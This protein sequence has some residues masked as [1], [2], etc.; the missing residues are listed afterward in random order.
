MFGKGRFGGAAEVVQ[1]AAVPHLL[2]TGLGARVARR[3][4]RGATVCRCRVSECDCGRT[5]SQ[6]PHQC[7]H[8]ADQRRHAGRTRAGGRL[9]GLRSRLRSL[10]R[11]STGRSGIRQQRHHGTPDLRPHRAC[12]RARSASET[13]TATSASTARRA[14]RSRR[15]SS[16]W[17]PRPRSTWGTQRR[18]APSDRCLRKLPVSRKRSRALRPRYPKREVR[19]RLRVAPGRIRPRQRRARIYAPR[20]TASRW[21]ALRAW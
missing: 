16:R 1:H 2:R 10:S 5:S 21:R 6:R 11:G 19:R 4:R 17:P 15:L 7:E 8:G 9:C 13:I 18:T 20:N 14:P 12:A 3:K